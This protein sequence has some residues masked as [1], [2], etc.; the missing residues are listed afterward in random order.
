MPASPR[1]NRT[2]R[3]GP[4]TCGRSE[5]V[6]SGRGSGA[7]CGQ[8]RPAMRVVELWRF[9]VKSTG[10][11]R[12]LDAEI[13]ELG[14]AGDRG[15]GLV[16]V[17]TGKVLTAR[18]AP[19]LLQ[20]SSRIVG[21]EVVVT[22]PDGREVGEGDAD[23]LSSWL[24]R[25]V[26]LRPA[27]DEGGVFETPMDVETESDWVSW[28]GPPGAWHD[29]TRTRVSLVSQSTL[30]DWDVRRFRTNVIVDGAG[31]DD[32]VGATIGIGD[33]RFDVTKQVDRCVMV[34]RPQPGLERDLDVLKRVNAERDGFLAI[35]CLVVSP[36]VVAVGDEVTRR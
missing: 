24:G 9:P 23:A 5:R 15:W 26:E 10:G 12:L 2:N 20:A 30:R 11:E 21:G 16:D 6:G 8:Y 1:T 3:A 22:L 4:E 36:G 33:A 25:S 28:Q 29:S 32:L 17:D 7:G 31:E 27:G 19:E 35:G 34:T 13:G 14:I 18:R